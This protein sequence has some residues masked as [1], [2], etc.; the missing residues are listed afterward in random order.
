MSFKFRRG[1]T[2]F[3]ENVAEQNKTKNKTKYKTKQS[4]AQNTKL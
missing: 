2:G 3:K 4:K 1:Q